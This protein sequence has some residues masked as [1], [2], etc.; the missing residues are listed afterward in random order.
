MGVTYLSSKLLQVVYKILN[1]LFGLIQKPSNFAG[2]EKLFLIVWSIKL[3][4]ELDIEKLCPDSLI[5]E[6]MPD[7]QFSAIAT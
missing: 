1:V 6:T 4:L 5:H 7:T 2:Y 3:C